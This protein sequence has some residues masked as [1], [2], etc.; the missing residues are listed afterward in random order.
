MS[1]LL[2]DDSVNGS[3]NDTVRENRTECHDSIHSPKNNN[4]STDE[5]NGL[6]S[7]EN[8]INNIQNNRG[9]EKVSLELFKY[10]INDFTNQIIRLT[11]E[12]TYLREDGRKKSD[13]ISKLIEMS[14]NKENT[15]SPRPSVDP[16][17]EAE[18]SS[19][20]PP[21]SSSP[22]LRPLNRPLNLDQKQSYSNILNDISSTH[23]KE[24]Q[25]PHKF[26]EFPRIYEEDRA[27]QRSNSSTTKSANSSAGRDEKEV[28]PPPS[29][30]KVPWKPNTV[31]I[32]GDSLLNGIQE[33]KMSKDGTI[34]VRA[35]PGAVIN[36]MYKF[37]QP[38]M[39]RKP[40]KIILHIG[41]NDA[42]GKT[43]D[44]ILY[45]LLQLK[46]FIMQKYNITPVISWPTLRTDRAKAKYV[47]LE[48]W[49]RLEQLNIPS[50][51]NTNITEDCLGKGGKNPGLHMNPKGY[52]RLA[53]N[54]LSYNRKH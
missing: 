25:K 50:I 18:K 35:F 29:T 37:I 27:D 21:F 34:K 53:M 47:I 22:V 43:S 3:G 24:I 36:D 8:V 48:L 2:F 5:H 54:F 40:S 12:V 20:N 42:V 14:C 13:M 49:K 11:D 44:E 51:S 17:T 38:H 28:T 52:G 16:N 23:N 46:A 1:I 33:K 19:N 45:E 6:K 39:E 7:L 32:I 31:L 4:A 26:F 30:Q 9:D 41:T 10:L 15:R